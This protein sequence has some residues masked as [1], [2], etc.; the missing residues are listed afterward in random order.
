MSLTRVLLMSG[1]YVPTLFSLTG[2]NA[3]ML[4]EKTA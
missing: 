3:G 2:R 1:A 4:C